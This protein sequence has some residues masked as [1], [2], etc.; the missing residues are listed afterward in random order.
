MAATTA[1]ASD[2]THAAAVSTHT[3]HISQILSSVVAGVEM[4]RKYR[5]DGYG[6]LPTD[7]EVVVS[8]RKLVVT[9]IV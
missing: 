5:R 1:I 3:S 7:E 2:L 9:L 4:T 8:L 6:A